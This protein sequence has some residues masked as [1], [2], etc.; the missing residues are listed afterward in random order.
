L[1]SSKYQCFWLNTMYTRGERGFSSVER[2]YAPN[3]R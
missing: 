1:V 3:S 2:F